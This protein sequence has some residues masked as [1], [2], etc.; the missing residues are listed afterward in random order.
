MAE[1]T[2]EY[3]YAN[4]EQGR[5]DLW[6][7]LLLLRK[8]IASLKAGERLTPVHYT[9]TQ[10]YKI[11]TEQPEVAIEFTLKDGMHFEFERQ[12]DKTIRVFAHGPKRGQF[13][14]HKRTMPLHKGK[15][16]HGQYYRWGSS[17]H[18]YYFK[19][20]KSERGEQGGTTSKALAKANAL[21]QARAIEAS[22][23]KQVGEGYPPNA[24]PQQ[25]A[26]VDALAKTGIKLGDNWTPAPKWYEAPITG[27]KNAA[28]EIKNNKLI[29]KALDY[30]PGGNYIKEAADKIGRGKPKDCKCQDGKGCG[31]Q[32]GGS[33]VETVVNAVKALPLPTDLSANIKSILST[34]GEELVTGVQVCRVP[35]IGA[36]QKVVNFLRQATGA[37]PN[38]TFD[39]LYHLYVIVRTAKG[40]WRL[41]MN[42]TYQMGAGGPS[43]SKDNTCKSVATPANTKLTAFVSAPLKYA[44]F[45]RYSA[46]DNNCQDHA[47]QILQ[48]NGI[49]SG[50][51]R[52]FIKQDT[53][54]LLPGFIGKIADGITDVAAKITN[55]FGRGAC[56]R[57]GCK[58]T[59]RHR[60]V[61]RKQVGGARVK[62][63]I[64]PPFVTQPNT[65]L[66]GSLPR[67][68]A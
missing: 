65:H 8:H 34:H 5:E 16:K 61:K 40:T 9:D 33:V 51:L 56:G 36:I 38:A 18:K 26:I 47:I 60:H 43:E 66:Y 57:G 22:K 68:F 64:P 50:D 28:T 2:T 30:V 12:R 42:Q 52:A 37:K 4:D 14:I 17:G 53:K 35:I 31:C 44:G 54:D 19:D 45:L 58:I 55:L 62:D 67:I 59:R 49:L 10:V 6:R 13:P 23:H 29:G 63:L 24:T 11:L 3:V 7:D 1:H 32:K 25:K 48:A 27:V 46:F 41:E 15:D 39:T 20:A 21:K